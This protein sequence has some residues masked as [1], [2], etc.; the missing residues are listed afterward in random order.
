[1]ESELRISRGWNHLKVAFFVFECI[2][3]YSNPFIA[4]P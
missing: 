2:S 1:M 3:K 4:W